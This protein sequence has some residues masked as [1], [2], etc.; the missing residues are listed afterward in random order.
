[1]TKQT[2][3]VSSEQETDLFTPIIKGSVAFCKR[4][5]SSLITGLVILI[6]AAVLG[7]A[8]CNHQQKITEKS[9]EAYYNAQVTLL[10]Q[11]QEATLPALDKVATDFPNTPAATYSVLQKGDL[12]YATENYAQAA[13]AYKQIANSK[14]ETLRTAATLSE[15]AALQASQD[16]DAAIDLMQNF[17]AKNPKNFALP[18]AYFTLALSQELSGNT[19]AALET[20]KTLVENYAKTYFGM[21]AKEKINELQK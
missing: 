5:K 14:S 9:W 10:S 7:A 15:G 21:V 6:L 11:G 19:P 3:P 16:Y 18:Q 4:N 1:M 17:I 20:Y 13:D 2:T 8:Y 12:L